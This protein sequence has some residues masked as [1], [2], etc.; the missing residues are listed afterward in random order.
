MIMKTDFIDACLEADELPDPDKFKLVDK[1]HEKRF[2]LSLIRS[3]D[4]AKE[5]QGRLLHGRS[6]Y[7][8]SSVNGGFD[9]YSQIVKANG[10]ECML[11]QG[12]KG[13]RVKSHRAGSEGVGEEITDVYL[14]SPEE[15]DN[16]KLWE[17]FESMAQ[18]SRMTPRIVS[19]DWLIETA[20]RQEI[21]P[22][23]K[24]ELKKH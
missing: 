11:W 19:T 4:R 21:L 13:T 12:R 15:P 8:M 5:N 17:Q 10:G 22:V 9:T 3:R 24:Y 6:V 14:V 1:E 20:M 2:G 7:C 16:K 18:A 23:A